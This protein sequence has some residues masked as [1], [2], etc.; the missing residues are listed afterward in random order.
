VENPSLAIVVVEE[1]E[2]GVEAKEGWCYIA[3]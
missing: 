2:K 1:R 3:Q